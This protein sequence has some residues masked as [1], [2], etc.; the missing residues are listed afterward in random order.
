MSAT[1]LLVSIHSDITRPLAMP[2]LPLRRN[3][4]GPSPIQVRRPGLEVACSGGSDRNASASATRTGLQERLS[5]MKRHRIDRGGVQRWEWHQGLPSPRTGPSRDVCDHEGPLDERETGNQLP[6]GQAP[7]AHRTHSGG[8][9]GRGIGPEGRGIR[10]RVSIGLKR[11]PRTP[12]T[13]HHCHFGP[14]IGR[15]NGAAWACLGPGRPPPYPLGGAWIRNWGF[16]RRAQGSLAGLPHRGVLPATSDC[17]RFP[18]R[19]ATRRHSMISCLPQ[20][21]SLPPGSGSSRRRRAGSARC[22]R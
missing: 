2:E 14:A 10:D 20:G 16:L 17:P 8:F 18:A 6:P 19:V 12:R 7:P 21:G 5:D 1:K 4:S 3:L 11:R 13:I 15:N 22:R 9:A